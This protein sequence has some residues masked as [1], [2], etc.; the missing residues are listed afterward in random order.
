MAR[1]G[2]W[3]PAGRRARL[4][5]CNGSGSGV[6]GQILGGWQGWGDSPEGWWVVGQVAGL[7]EGPTQGSRAGQR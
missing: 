3:G 4:C 1:A 7:V 5:T 6:P 2:R